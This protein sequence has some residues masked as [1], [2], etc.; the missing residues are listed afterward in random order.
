ASRWVKQ[1]SKHLRSGYLLPIDKLRKRA[2]SALYYSLY[3]ELLGRKIQEYNIQP[4]NT[5]NIDKKGFLIG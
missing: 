4:G 1:H 5:W 3:I 2:D